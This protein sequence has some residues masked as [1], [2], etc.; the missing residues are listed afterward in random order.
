MAITKILK[1]SENKDWAPKHLRQAIEY[2]CRDEK[3]G[4]GRYVGAVGCIPDHA[5]D[6][7][8]DTKKLFAKKD[9][10][11]GYHLI[12][13]FKE[14][15]VDPKTA[16]EIV[17]KFV[18][19]YLN[20][21]YEAVY[22][23]HTDTDHIHGHIIFNS[24]NHIS[25][26]KYQYRKG[27][28]A[29]YIQPITNRLCEEYGLS[30]IDLDEI[31][32]RGKDFTG[33][34]ADS[35]GQESVLAAMIRRD[36]DSALLLSLD[37]E[38]F[39]RRLEDMGYEIREGK[40]L[41]V[42]PMGMKRFRRTSALG[43]RYTE[44][45]L[46]RRV[47]EETIDTYRHRKKEP[48]ILRVKVPPHIRRANL[49]GV[50]K[51]YFRKLYETGQ[52]RKHPY[53]K[54]WQF[55]DEI[56]R[57]HKLQEQYLFLAKYELHDGPGLVRLHAA[58]NEKK[59]MQRKEQSRIYKERAKL[60]PLFEITDRLDQL[61][62]AELAYQD[63]DDFF[64]EEH[65][66]YK[67]FRDKLSDQGYSYEDVKK[68]EAHYQS[69]LARYRDLFKSINKELRICGELVDEVVAYDREQERQQAVKQEAPLEEEL[70]PK[71]SGEQEDKVPSGP[72]NPWWIRSE[73]DHK[74]R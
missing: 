51:R 10:V 72:K 11:Q 61:E 46:R 34:F 23:V 45:E 71:R 56:K 55:R 65:R 22:S 50:Q 7:M 63:G 57:F 29:Q 62:P 37:Y 38:S 74:V 30:T 66:E 42:R 24:V 67:A 9:K 25:G 60:K 26:R 1:I 18:D 13:S 58:L 15:E 64:K 21:E 6:Q 2:I 17:G 43:E 54:A 40:Q 32:S 59:K 4:Y 3:T 19:E 68:L 16:F 53:S 12:I 70:V 44:E 52:L 33:R 5:L 48:R 28:W 35:R 39:L 20:G 31:A 47:E 14:G 49:S 73:P 41:T 69:E 27:D 36:F 8:L